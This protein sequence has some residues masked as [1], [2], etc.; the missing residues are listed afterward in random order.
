MW[1]SINCVRNNISSRYTPII[2]RT[3]K[4]KEKTDEDD[5][6]ELELLCEY[7]EKVG[8]AINKY[9]PSGVHNLDEK[10]LSTAPKKVSTFQ[11]RGQKMNKLKTDT[12]PDRVYSALCVVAANGK[13][14]PITII[15]NGV[16]RDS[17]SSRMVLDAVEPFG[18]Y[19][20]LT[21]SG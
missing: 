20:G 5:A 12:N 14:L 6:N 18:N 1:W 7:Y 16:R 19:M 17:A 10:P 2:N 21:V 13:K 4:E 8:N 3:K 11:F 15:K 9:G